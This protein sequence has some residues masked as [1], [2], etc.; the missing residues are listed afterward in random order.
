V[1]AI[2]LDPTG[3][4]V[5][6]GMPHDAYLR[7]PALSASGAKLLV[8][9]GGP[10]RYRWRLDHPE[11]PRAAF[12]LGTA[13]HLAVLGAGPTIVAVD[14]PDW[15]T[16]RAQTERD[17]A[18]AAGCVPL[19]FR[20]AE[21]VAD[22]A[23][24]LRAHPIASRV[25]LPGSGRPEV[26]LFW[27]DPEY[28]VDRRARVDW[29]RNAD[30]TGRLLLV[31][32][33]TT[34]SADPAA[35]D[36]AIGNH[37]YHLSA[38]WYRDVLIGL[39]LATTVPVLLVFQETTPPYLPHVVELGPE[40]LQTGYDLVHRALT[41]YRQCVDSGQWPGYDVITLSHPPA[42]LLHQHD[43]LIGDDA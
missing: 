41:V 19:L 30:D 12:D 6:D 25:L 35:I 40:W 43:A 29:L 10:A 13:A 26:S 11:P 18:R 38:A 8:Q 22:M 14:A 1:T 9:P 36:R 27:H 24:A 17:E 7:H 37:G 4:A 31:D 21:R 28:G 16:K 3:G 20:D 5:V 42:W 15:R 39:G 34:A 2:E 33:K 23:A 32:Y